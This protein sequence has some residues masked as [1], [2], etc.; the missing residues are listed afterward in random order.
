MVDWDEAHPHMI[1][2]NDEGYK[3][4]QEKGEVIKDISVSLECSVCPMSH[5]NYTVHICKC[6]GFY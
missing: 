2:K 3:K 4:A 1:W 6:A 5:S